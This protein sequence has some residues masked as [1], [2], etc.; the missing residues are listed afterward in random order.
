MVMTH[1]MYRKTPTYDKAPAMYGYDTSYILS[2]RRLLCSVY[3]KTPSSKK[4]PSM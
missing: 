4:T 2:I 1:L 3:Y